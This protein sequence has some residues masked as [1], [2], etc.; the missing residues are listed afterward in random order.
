[1]SL[2]GEKDVAK[3]K[4][5]LN[6]LITRI[7]TEDLMFDTPISANPRFVRDISGN[8]NIFLGRKDFISD[9]VNIDK[10]TYRVYAPA[11][12]LHPNVCQLFFVKGTKRGMRTKQQQLQQQQQ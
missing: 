12:S 2:K 1:M 7:S 11:V 3:F 8:A 4:I 9:I 6:F 10:V 5:K